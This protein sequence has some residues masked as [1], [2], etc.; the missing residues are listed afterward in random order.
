[1]KSD[2]ILRLLVIEL[3]LEDAEYQLSALRNAG[4]AVRPSTA[5][6]LDQIQ[7]ALERQRLDLILANVDHE[8]MPIKSIAELVEKSGKDVPII[9]LLD[10]FN[11]E[12]FAKAVAD[13]AITATS[14]E[15][16]DLAVQMVKTAR[17]DLEARRSLET[18]ETALKES[19]KRNHALLDSSRDPIAYVH[20]GMHVYANSAYLNMFGHEDFDDLAGYSILD[21][22]A[23]DHTKQL[24]EI[25]KDLSKGQPPPDHIEIQTRM[26]DGSTKDALMEFSPASIEGEPCTQIVIRDKSVD[27]RLAEELT[28]LKNRDLV[29]GLY[30][31]QY[32]AQVLNDE[33][34]K[35]GHDEVGPAIAYVNI[36]NFKHTLDKVGL[37]GVD[38]I[39]G[40]L[41]EV[42]RGKLTEQDVPAR[43]GDQN[44]A[45]M[46]P[47]K[48]LEQ[49]QQWADKLR[50]AVEAHISDVG[51]A[52]ITLTVS[53]GVTIITESV[54][55]AQD[56]LSIASGAAH[57]A[58]QD[59]GNK[60]EIYDPSKISSADGEDNIRWIETVRA[61][62]KEERLKLYFQPIVSLHGE[63]GE[64]YEVLV[65]MITSE[66]EEILP[67]QFMPA[68]ADH[69]LM[70]DMDRWIIEKS[71][72]ALKAKVV[73]TS[74]EFKFFLKL[75]PQTVAQPKLLPWLAQS[76]KKHR[77]SGEHLVFEMPE[78]K[79]MTNLK[80]AKQFLKGI[81]QLH[82]GFALEQFGSGLNSFQ[83][84]KHLSADY[85]KIDRAFMHDLPK[86]AEN[87]EKVKEI[88]NQAHAQGKITIAEFVE[89]ASSMSILWQAGVN[90]VQGNFLQE[91]QPKMNYDFGG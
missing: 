79:V 34:E 49:A 29:T 65:R 33:I 72:D 51:T 71:I 82:C 3:S 87:Q 83:I 28:D 6:D 67:G 8:E 88:S 30:N 53:V 69:A 59:G 44:L 73:D 38:L 57:K 39:L 31:R 56:V 40:D 43:F 47:G 60:V 63:E 25:L 18:L 90:F 9:A 77:I 81:K 26:P 21:M 37:A 10:D 45:I 52:S 78:S 5:E 23:G 41:A 58:S 86:S 35:V 89:D 70:V 80:P 54:T 32:M 76:L 50:A 46:L 13:G 75:A 91:P 27:P 11:A 2:D 85:L 14:S 4:I 61:A 68:I 66:G 1:M 62:I 48:S 19:E 36:D 16:S 24:R 12:S 17:T 22:V 55:D 15:H 64:R 7:G 42:I 84:L 74:K 20:E